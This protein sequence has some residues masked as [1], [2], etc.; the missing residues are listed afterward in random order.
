MVLKDIKGAMD[1]GRFNLAEGGMERVYQVQALAQSAGIAEAEMNRLLRNQTNVDELFAKRKDAVNVTVEQNK[2]DIQAQMGASEKIKAAPTNLKNAIVLAGSAQKDFNR[3]V[4]DSSKIMEKHATAV[5]NA[6]HKISAAVSGVKVSVDTWKGEGPESKAGLFGQLLFG[7]GDLFDK[8]VQDM[9]GLTTDMGELTTTT[10]QQMEDT[11][12]RIQNVKGQQEGRAPAG[13][14]I[15][16]TTGAGTAAPKN[17]QITKQ[18]N[19]DIK[20]QIN[21]EIILPANILKDSV[22][23]EATRVMK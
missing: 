10:I 1:E 9:K 12:Q 7:R 14:P 3:I 6:I 22:M 18:P 5:G 19:G 2:K 15:P 17:Q 4:A 8:R 13:Q 11:A 20:V 23:Q 21:Q 16:G